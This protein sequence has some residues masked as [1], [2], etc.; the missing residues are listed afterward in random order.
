MDSD[1]EPQNAP[2]LSQNGPPNRPKIALNI[3][4]KKTHF[5]GIL[6]LFGSIPGSSGAS[7][8]SPKSILELRE[9]SGN[10]FWSSRG[11]FS[12]LRDPFWSSQDEFSSLREPISPPEAL[13]AEMRQNSLTRIRSAVTSLHSKI[14]CKITEIPPL[15]YP[16]L[17]CGG[18]AKRSQSAGP[19]VFRMEPGS[20]D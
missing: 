3:R 15:Q 20:N 5:C 2:K 12:N 18:L 14:P 9:P 16:S 7:R 8:G 17:G 10:Q 19:S 6:G 13:Q 11:Q 1:F 4:K